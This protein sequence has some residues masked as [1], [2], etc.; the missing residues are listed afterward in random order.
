M[1]DTFSQEQ[2]YAIP[3][4]VTGKPIEIGGSLGR[5]ESTGRGVVYTIS[6][7]PSISTCASTAAPPS[8]CT[9]SAKSARSRP[10]RWHRLGC[11][12]LAVSDVSGGIYNKNGLI[13]MTS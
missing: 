4:V 8:P 12:V 6:R 11:K 3:G 9:A 7:P 2:G 13:S 5:A 1:M 10:K